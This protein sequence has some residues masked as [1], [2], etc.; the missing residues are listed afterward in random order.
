MNSA[1]IFT[2]EKRKII[3]TYTMQKKE[4]SISIARKNGTNPAFNL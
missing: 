2:E 3:C 1:H 4:V